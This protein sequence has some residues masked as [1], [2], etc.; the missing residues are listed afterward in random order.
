M[1]ISLQEKYIKHS[2]HGAHVQ[3]WHERKMVGQAARQHPRTQRIVIAGVLQSL[4]NVTSHITW[5][6]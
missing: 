4:H 2:R 6:N 5:G 1:Y 3:L